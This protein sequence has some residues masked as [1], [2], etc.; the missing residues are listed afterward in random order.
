MFAAPPL[1]PKLAT[2][3]PK[4]ETLNPNRFSGR[5]VQVRREAAADP[6]QVSAP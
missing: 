6:R 2:L 1:N 4:L 5:G 3:N